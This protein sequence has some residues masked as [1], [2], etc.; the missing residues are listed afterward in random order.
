M[1][2]IIDYSAIFDTSDKKQTSFDE[3]ELIDLPT[4]VLSKFKTYIEDNFFPIIKEN[5]LDC[6]DIWFIGC[7]VL[8]LVNDRCY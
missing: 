6:K 1:I 3:Y 2:Y 5:G 8:F 7:E 4:K